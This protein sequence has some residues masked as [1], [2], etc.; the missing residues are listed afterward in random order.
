MVERVVLHG[1]GERVDGLR[2]ARRAGE[3][4]TQ[5]GVVPIVAASAGG[6]IAFSLARGGPWVSCQWESQTHRT[7][8]LSRVPSGTEV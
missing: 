5:Q 8:V 2:R 6:V 7:T 1:K 4:E 3:G